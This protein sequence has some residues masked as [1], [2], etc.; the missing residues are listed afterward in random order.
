MSFLSGQLAGSSLT[1]TLLF[2]EF[3]GLKVCCG[4]GEVM[5]V[6]PGQ[7]KFRCLQLRRSAW[8]SRLLVLTSCS[9]PG[10]ILCFLPGWQEI[11]GVQQRLLETLGSQNSRYLVLPGETG[12]GGADRPLGLR[13]RCSCCSEQAWTLQY[14]YF[15]CNCAC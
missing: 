14:M 1:W 6:L 7:Q 10:G 9:V 2:L 4:L 5:G 3:L 11:K 13:S 8:I 15:L 12:F